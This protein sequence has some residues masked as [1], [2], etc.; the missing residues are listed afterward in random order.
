MLGNDEDTEEDDNIGVIDYTQDEN[1]N[2]PLRFQ[3]PAFW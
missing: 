1:G 3:P 2:K